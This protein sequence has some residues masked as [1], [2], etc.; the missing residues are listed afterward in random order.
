M[1]KQEHA[2]AYVG[3]VGDS[4]YLQEVFERQAMPQ[5]FSFVDFIPFFIPAGVDG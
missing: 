4:F 1:G 5:V 2:A 3:W